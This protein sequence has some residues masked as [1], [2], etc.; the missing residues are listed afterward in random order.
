M[1]NPRTLLAAL[2]AAVVIFIWQSI[3][4]MLLPW[5]HNALNG[6]ENEAAMEAAILEQAKSNGELKD[7]MYMLPNV[8]PH[9]KS[10]T[11]EQIRTEQEA[12]MKQW[13]EGV[14][15]F[16]AVS[17]QG[18]SGFGENLVKQFLF[19]LAGAL[20]ITFLL[21]KLSHDGMGCRMGVTVFFSLFAIVTTILPNWA[22]WAFSGSFTGFL[23]FDHLVGWI[24]GGFVLAKLVPKNEVTD[25]PEAVAEE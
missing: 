18:R 2:A 12:A 5:Q 11:K 21:T 8:N 23:I 22:W 14:S 3:S 13:T 10:K 19:N 20:L 9:D 24:L 15:I 6:F 17:T 25:A 16:A 7:G 1:R 4:H